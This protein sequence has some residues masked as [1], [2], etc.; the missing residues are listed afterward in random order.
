MR[1]MAIS[2]NGFLILFSDVLAKSIDVLSNLEDVK[3]LFNGKERFC[4]HLS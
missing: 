4:D 2:K 1:F 3:F